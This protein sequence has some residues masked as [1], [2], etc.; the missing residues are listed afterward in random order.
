[1]RAKIGRNNPSTAFPEKA[2]ARGLYPGPGALVGDQIPD[3]HIALAVDAVSGNACMWG[4][5]SYLRLS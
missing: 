5:D 3:N 4:L 2:A 1:M